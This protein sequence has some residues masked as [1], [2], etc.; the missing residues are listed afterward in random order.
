M[1]LESITIENF[2]NHRKLEF[3]PG[4]SITVIHGRNGTGKTSILEAV[5]YCAFTRGFA[6][7]TDRECLSFGM[8]QFIIRGLF[9]SDRNLTTAVRIAY[10]PEKEKQVLVNEQEMNSFSRHIGTIPCITFTPGEL[11]IVNGAPSERRRFLDT[12]ICQYDRKYLADMMQYRRVLQQR[13]ALLLDGINSHS[14]MAAFDIWTDQIASLA[15]TIVISRLEFI[16]KFGA[17][18]VA[19]Y[20]WFPGDLEPEI[21]YQSSYG[22]FENDQDKEGITEFFRGR[23]QSL[24]EQE[25]QRRQTLAGPHRDDLLLLTNGYET[26]KYASQGEQRS[27]LIAMKMALRGYL[28]EITNEHPIIIFD[29]IFSELDPATEEIILK[30]LLLYGQVLITSTIEINRP[31]ILNCAVQNMVKK[32]G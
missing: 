25:I 23:H 1:R 17:M 9:N 22:K 7:S 16:R 14:T 30:D 20:S 31:G 8:D 26:R 10:A 5:H 21:R 18:F 2:R 19:T 28:Y 15:A 24:K 29:D 6:G 3:E 27:Y 11:A 32:K 12:S 4:P 13:N